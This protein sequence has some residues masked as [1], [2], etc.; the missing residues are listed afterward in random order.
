M[1]LED[2]IDSYRSLKSEQTTADRHL[3][4]YLAIATVSCYETFFRTIVK[5]FIDFGSPYSDN[6]IKLD[7]LNI[8]ID[9]DTLHAIQSQFITLGDLISHLLPFNNLKDIDRNM[10]IITGKSFL[11]SLKSYRSKS[12][13]IDDTEKNY[14]TKNINTI[15]SSIE[16]VFELRHIFCHEFNNNINF[17]SEV[18][19]TNIIDCK[20]FIN[21]AS[22]YFTNI[23]Y[24]NL[25]QTQGEMNIYSLENFMALDNELDNLINEIKTTNNAGFINIKLFDKSIVYWKK[26]RQLAAE[27]AAYYA[28]GGSV[29]SLE[30]NTKMSSLTQEKLRLL[31][32]EFSRLLAL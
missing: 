16:K 31:K 28:K 12:L 1:R 10:S 30:Y 9:F 4:K 26:Y 21:Y 13:F 11:K 24:P 2:L 23:L 14:F 27:C 6:I 25:P 17:D 7:Q 22:D 18:L 3:I 8:K 15:I 20:V 32:T 19:L 5:D 29:Y